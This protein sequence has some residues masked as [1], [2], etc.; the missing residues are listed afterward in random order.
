M[1]AP[2]PAMPAPGPVREEAAPPPD[3]TTGEP[4]AVIPASAASVLVSLGSTD[5]PACADGS[6]LL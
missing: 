5:A 4:P 3:L 2:S 1:S 6:C